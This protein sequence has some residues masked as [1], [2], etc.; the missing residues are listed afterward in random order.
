MK[1]EN[2]PVTKVL[3]PYVLGILVAYIGDFSEK[4][5]QCFLWSAAV[6]YVLS[7][8]LTYLKSYRWRWLRTL[9]MCAAFLMT[10][11]TLTNNKFQP[12]SYLD[13]LASSQDW[14]VRVAEEPAKKGKSVKVDAEVMQSID[15]KVNRGRILLYLQSSEAASALRY[16]DL[17]LVH[18]NLSRIAPPCN[19]DG[20]DNQLYM[21]RRGIYYF[22]FVR[23]GAWEYVG[24][25]PANRLKCLAQK[26]RNHLT[27]MYVS[28]GMSGE[29]LDVLK[30]ILLGDDDT[31]DPE[32]RAS[33]SSAGVSHILCVSGMHVGVI[34]MIINF[35]LKPLDFFRASRFCKTILVLLLIWLYAHIT[36]LAPSVTRSA[37]MFTFVAVGQVLRRNTNVFHSLFASAFI[38]LVIN[39]LLLFEVGFQLSYLAVAG[40]V[41]FQPKL[42]AIYQCRTR[43]G[44]YFWELL[45]VSVAAQLGT[46]PISIYYFAQFP[47]YFML[48][49]LSVIALS[50]LVIVT[51][52]ALLPVSLIPFVSKCLSW[53]LTMEIRIMNSVIQFVERLPHAVTENIDYHIVQVILL[54]GVIGCFC[55]L[56]HQRSR[57]VFWLMCGLFVSFCSSFSVRKLRMDR[58]T[59]FLTYHI[60]KCSA[61]SFAF[62]G[63]AVLFS[64]SIRSSDD[65]LYQYN[66]RN[67]VLR[68]HQR[69]VVVPCD[70]SA[71]DTPFLCKR[72]NFIRF[73][74][75]TYYMLTRKEEIFG[76]GL[77]DS[78]RVDCLLLRQNPRMLPESLMAAL[79][80][81][82]VVADGSNTPFYVQRWRDFCSEKGIPFTYTADRNLS[83]GR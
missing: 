49:N 9:V 63:H 44:K 19:P 12:P 38:L 17:L 22:G 21:R 39:P 5:C 40:I 13:Q 61:V 76:I 46:S 31:L 24:N 20:F 41:L 3:F 37:A 7:A 8:G 51:G 18:A 26:A 10:G 53:L 59:E 11:I 4:V 58:E 64:D 57:K 25:Q 1:I 75:K 14:F 15:N 68:H 65:K 81:S 23:D 27:S 69:M 66:V 54:Y 82:E 35:L 45:T 43:I 36:G 30:A 62:A 47:N 71:Y 74:D 79:P 55:Y 80:F 32:L 50:F 6:L 72:G 2:Y 56:L 78:L 33:Y 52:V 42:G 83:N 28:A 34:F 60:R 16:G 73:R 48:S 29:E 77:S 70:T 67:H